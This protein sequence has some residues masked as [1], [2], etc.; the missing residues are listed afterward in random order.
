MYKSAIKFWNCVSVAVTAPTS[1]LLVFDLPFCPSYV[2]PVPEDCF[3]SL[4]RG[5]LREMAVAA[6]AAEV[7]LEFSY[8]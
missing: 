5:L 6:A 1:E 4:W 2:F 3:S 7:K 8:N